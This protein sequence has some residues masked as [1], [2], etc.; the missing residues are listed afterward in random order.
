MNITLV[1]Q[2]VSGKALRKD[3]RYF[4]YRAGHLFRANF[5]DILQNHSFTTLRVNGYLDRYSVRFQKTCIQTMPL[6][7]VDAVLS[8][9]DILGSHFRGLPAEIMDIIDSYL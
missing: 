2:V 3:Q 7:W 5:I 4:F 6:S 9:Q 1:E 8:L